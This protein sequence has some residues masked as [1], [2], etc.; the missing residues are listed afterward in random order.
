MGFSVARTMNGVGHLVGLA[1][2]RDLVL[3]HDLEQGGLDLG[4]RAVDLVG[5][6]EVGEDRAELR[7]ERAVGRAVDARPD[8]VGGHQ[9]RGE[10]DAL[11]AA[12]QD[13]GE[14]LDGQRLGQAGDALEQD[15]AAG[16]E[17]DEDALEHLVLA[18]DDPSDLEQDG[19]GHGARVGRVGQGAQ[20]GGRRGL[21]HGW[22]WH[23]GPGWQSVGSAVV[24]PLPSPRF[25]KVR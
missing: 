1:A 9:V 17:A 6:Q 14:G 12:A 15:V 18:D 7:L 11:E 3:L 13:V 5:Q 20:V 10:L 2:D 8:E 22:D 21:G 19:L 23:R 16:Q 24:W 25:L 4:R